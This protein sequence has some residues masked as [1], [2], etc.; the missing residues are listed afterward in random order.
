MHESNS[1]TNTILIV[2]LILIVVGFGAYWYTNM[3][4]QKADTSNPALQ[5][6]LGTG[7]EGGSESGQ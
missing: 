7:G 1:G 6:N 4:G 5:I 3:K 2:I